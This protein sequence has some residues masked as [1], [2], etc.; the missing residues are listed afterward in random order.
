MK[1]G[2]T[3]PVAASDYVTV[4]IRVIGSESASDGG[5]SRASLASSIERARGSRS[6][7]RDLRGEKG[8]VLSL[9]Q[10]GAISDR[11]SDRREVSGS[12]AALA[13][14][15][16]ARGRGAA[17]SAA[18]QKGPSETFATLAAAIQHELNAWLTNPPRSLDNARRGSVRA[19]T[20]SQQGSALVYPLSPVA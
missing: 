14:G 2:G 12:H 15:G 20:S 3:K 9:R 11:V 4:V 6:A 13:G 19:S 5:V 1:R 17:R 8:P 7:S 18:P 10:E 16:R